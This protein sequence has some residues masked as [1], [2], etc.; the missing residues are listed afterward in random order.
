VRRAGVLSR[1]AGEN[2]GRYDILLGVGAKAGNY[3]ISFES[4]NNAFTIEG[5]AMPDLT[6]SRDVSEIL[7]SLTSTQTQVNGT[8]EPFGTDGISELGGR[9]KVDVAMGPGGSISQGTLMDGLIIDRT[10][11]ADQED[12]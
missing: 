6:I 12:E 9:D 3:A 10:G 4:D 11:S 5:R 7:S 8:Q 2:F 1:E